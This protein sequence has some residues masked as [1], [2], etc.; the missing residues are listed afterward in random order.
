MTKVVN[1]V[2]QALSAPDVVQQATDAA[3]WAAGASQ[4]A[5]EEIDSSCGMLRWQRELVIAGLPTGHPQRVKAAA[6]EAQAAP[7]RG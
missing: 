3:A 5:L 1:G 4:R 2:V 7:L 6:A